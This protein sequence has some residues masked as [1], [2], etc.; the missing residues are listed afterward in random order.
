MAVAHFQAVRESRAV[1]RRRTPRRSR[2]IKGRLTSVFVLFLI[3][4]TILGAFSVQ[5]LTAVNRTSIEIR[6]RWLRST[7]ALGD[8]N[9]FTSD[10]RAAEASRLLAGT[11]AE[12]SAAERELGAL[13][14]AVARARADYERIGHDDQEWGAYGRFAAAWA[15]YRR[16]AG[17]TLDLARRDHRDA[18][19]ALYIGASRRAYDAASDD[20]GVLTRL[21]VVRAARASD[22]ATKTYYSALGVIA[23]VV[24]LA[25]V[26]LIVAV[27]YITRS[28]SSPL[29]NLAG[30]MR[31]I[32]ASDTSGDVEG[33]ER[34]DEIGEMARAVVVFRNN[35][36]ELAHS[37]LGLVR[38]AAMLA[39][40][41]EAE[42]RLT[43][44][45]RNFVSMAL[46]EFRTPLTHIDAQAQRLATLRARVTPEDIGER[47]GRI[48]RA[49]QRMTN[50]MERLLNASRLLDGEPDLYFHPTEIRP[51][52]LLRQVCHLHREI[53]P[54]AWIVETL[55]DLPATMVADPDLLTQAIGNLL[56]NAVKYSPD[57]GRIDV[58]AQSDGE[59]LVVVV[60]DRGLG[61]PEP[62]RRRVFERYHRGA[63]VAGVVGTGVGLYLVKMVVDLHGGDIGVDSQEGRGSRFT[64]RLPL[65]D[66]RSKN[67]VSA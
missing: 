48:R 62:D 34:R 42:Q 10:A 18:G 38:Q 41:L 8:L 56:S 2:S 60:Q 31:S 19:A 58:A 64:M 36:I 11:P 32:A 15:N 6:D 9:N 25:G 26:S 13:R 59:W 51:A 50:V 4:I 53:A 33:A 30:R 17:D 63:N 46:H 52:D 29:L 55:R 67:S 43:N 40:K 12:A 22:E 54:D 20:L 57:G 1:G 7:R 28:I 61:I 23:L 45:Q 27:H 5:E 37:Q 39:E 3:Q 24:A 44:L 21:T 14:L 35:A 16:V 65:G 66:R 47:A 49:V